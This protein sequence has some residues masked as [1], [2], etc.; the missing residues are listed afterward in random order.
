MCQISFK[1][2]DHGRYIL[3]QEYLSFLEK[4]LEQEVAVDIDSTELI[5]SLRKE[6]IYH[7]SV[8]IKYPRLRFLI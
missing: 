5:I 1:L 4:F 8:D 6:D 2:K 7:D 3:K